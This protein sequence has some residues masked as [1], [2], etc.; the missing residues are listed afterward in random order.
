MSTCRPRNPMTWNLRMAE[1]AHA[2]S[3]VIPHEADMRSLSP[4]TTRDLLLQLRNLCTHRD[5]EACRDGQLAGLAVPHVKGQLLPCY[6][7]TETGT[8]Q[9][10]RLAESVGHAH[11]HI[12]SER[13][14]I[15]NHVGWW[16]AR[17]DRLDRACSHLVRP[18]CCCARRETSVFVTFSTPASCNWSRTKI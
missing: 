9:L 5:L 7:S 12:A 3:S 13:P 14:A 17:R 4:Q 10:Q 11:D 15:A 8:D 2:L 6:S 16:H 18:C 1:L